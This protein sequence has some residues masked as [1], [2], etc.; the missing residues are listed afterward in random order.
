MDNGVDFEA[1]AWA[2][3]KL[4]AYGVQNRSMDNAM[5]MDRLNLMLLLNT[6]QW[7]TDEETQP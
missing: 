7:A 1:I 2:Y 3:S 6:E 4:S 5:M